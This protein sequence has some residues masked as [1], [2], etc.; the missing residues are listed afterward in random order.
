MT[1]WL[2]NGA[3]P[4]AVGQMVLDAVVNNR[5]YIHTDRVMYAG[6]EARMRALL[7]AMP[8]EDADRPA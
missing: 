2:A 4:D 5:L 1:D 3:P 7:E 8:A 6:I